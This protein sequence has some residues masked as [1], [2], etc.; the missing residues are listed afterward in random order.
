MEIAIMLNVD[1]PGIVTSNVFMPGVVIL[2]VVLQGFIM[3]NVVAPIFNCQ[4][5]KV[6][7]S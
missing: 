6:L 4:V 7:S 1:I 5:K 3:L 2:N